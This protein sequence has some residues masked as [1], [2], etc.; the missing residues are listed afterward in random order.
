MIKL[1]AKSFITQKK[2]ESRDDCQDARHQNDPNEKVRRYAVADGATRSFFPKK[3]AELLVEYFCE[4]SVPYPTIDNWKAWIKPIQ[5]EWLAQ[6]SARVKKRPLFYLVNS[7]NSKEAATSTFIGLEF[8]RVQ[9]RWKAMIIGDS[10]LFHIGACG[11]RSYMIDKT[12]DFTSR[13]EVFASY[14]KDNRWEPDFVA[15][16]ANPGDTFV[17]ATDALAKWILEHKEEGRYDE[18]L[19]K[20]NQIV[21][22]EQF[23]EFVDCA[24]TDEDIRLVNDDV[25]L[26]IISVEEDEVQG[27]PQV[28]AE[29]LLAEPPRSQSEWSPI[30]FWTMVAVFFGLPI[31]CYMCW[32][33]FFTDKD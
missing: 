5:E 22:E 15:D 28:T 20:L 26:T 13:P 23:Y 24:R 9:G 18:T 6:I 11:F 33:L 21:N 7:L 10:C 17:L 2:A 30:L 27:N 12:A 19:S 14:E 8:D 16:D 29:C 32:L 1:I 31:L 4:S 3:W 25:S